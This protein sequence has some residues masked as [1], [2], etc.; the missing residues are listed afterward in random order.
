MP[1]VHLRL[2]S[3][4]LNAV[5][6]RALQ[7][8]LTRLMETV[9]RKQARLTVVAIER[10]DPVFWSTGGEALS[11]GDWVAQLDAF[12]TAGTNTSAER[13]RFVAAAHALL[14]EHLGPSGQTREGRLPEP[15]SRAPVYVMVH[16][17][18]ADSWGYDGLTQE[19]RRQVAGAVPRTL[20]SWTS[21]GPARLPHPAESALVLIDFQREYVDGKLPLTGISEAARNATRLVSAATAAK[22]PVIH[23]H[24]EST[25]AGAIL[26]STGGTGIEPIEELPV[27][28]NQHRIVKT[29]PSAFHETDLADLLDRLLVKTVVLAG[30]MTHNCVDSTAR[31]ALHRG[32]SVVVV[33]EACATRDLPGPSGGVIPA[34]QVQ[35]A[36]LAA[37]ADR[38]A[39]VLDTDRLVQAWREALTAA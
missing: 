28:L 25:S 7:T 26:F 34:D 36:S 2:A 23:V 18:P 16:E 17:V 3:Q 38:H 22:V 14:K 37:L 19:A 21:A 33:G 20:R 32:Y 24:H 39:D 13:S 6:R 11:V 29:M 10:T 8:G 12:V 30:C 15:R 31:E 5:H 1:F 27:Q 35:A 4:S 9:L